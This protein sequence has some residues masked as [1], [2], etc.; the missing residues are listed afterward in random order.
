MDKKENVTTVGPFSIEY[1]SEEGLTVK[2]PGK[3]SISNKLRALQTGVKLF[4]DL[5]D[6]AEGVFSTIDSFTTKEKEPEST[7]EEPD[8]K[9]ETIYCATTEEALNLI[10]ETLKKDKETLKNDET[11]TIIMKR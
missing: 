1:N 8:K 7:P 3:D 4:N 9:E 2:M 11:I 6:L 10:R 5:N